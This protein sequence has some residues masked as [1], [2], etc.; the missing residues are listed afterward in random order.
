MA[1]EVGTNEEAKKE[2][3]GLFDGDTPFGTPNPERL[4]QRILHIATNP[5]D[6]VLD[7]FLGSGT[8]AALA[9]KMGRRWIGVEMGDHAVT[10][11]QPRLAKVI[12]GEG[13]GISAAVG[14]QGGGGFDFYRL[15]R[16]C[17]TWTERS[18][19][20]SPSPRSPRM[21]GSR[22]WERRGPTDPP[23]LRT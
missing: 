6:L 11:C 10:H 16:R 1:D 19:R 15:A 17:S 21:S 22:R 12:A 7:S 3:L 2:I 20:A 18:P 8:T 4:V 9:H 5:G 13:G 23:S 14:W